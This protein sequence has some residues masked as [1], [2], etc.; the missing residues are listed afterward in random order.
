MIADGEV[1]HTRAGFDHDSGTLMPAENGKA[2]H[3]DT[4]GDEVVIG[5]AHT[6]CFEL[7]LD[8]VFAWIA[9]LDFLD[10]PR[11]VEFPDERAFGLHRLTAFVMSG[12]H[13]DRRQI[14]LYTCKA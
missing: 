2:R 7:D 14:E 3:G 4:A 13:R 8:L 6:G 9:D 1:F 12:P 5:V 10:R 11:L